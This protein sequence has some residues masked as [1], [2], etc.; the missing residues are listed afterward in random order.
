MPASTGAK[1]PTNPLDFFAQFLSAWPRWPNLAPDRLQQSNTSSVMSGGQVALFATTVNQQATANPEL[2][3][4]I[5]TQVASYGKQLGRLM[6]AVD[7]LAGH[8]PADLSPNE[9]SALRNLQELA[10]KIVTA[11]QESANGRADQV[12]DD[13]RSLSE[14]PEENRQALK[15]IRDIVNQA[16]V[17]ASQ[18]G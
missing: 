12:V 2:E 17:R 1:S 15:R 8:R 14:A 18:P 9:E 3:Q 5:V 11:R 16:P 6:E 10:A 7:V 13:V 4:Q